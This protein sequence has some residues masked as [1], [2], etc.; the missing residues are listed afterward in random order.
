MSVQTRPAAIAGFGQFQQ[1]LARCGRIHRFGIERLPEFYGH[2]IRKL[3]RPF[4]KKSP[5]L[6]GKD[7]TPKLIEPNG[8]DGRVR[9]SR[10]Q[11]VTTAQ[12]EQRP[13]SRELTFGKETDDLA[14]S[15]F[16]CRT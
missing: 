3:P 12:A 5:A 2:A 9:L 16:F 14:G 11:L 13:G 6:K 15:N 4:P 10:D 8:N 1:L 7:R